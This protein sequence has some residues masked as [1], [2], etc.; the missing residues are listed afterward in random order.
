V[1]P[2]SIRL[3]SVKTFKPLGTLSYH[4]ESCTTLVFPHSIDNQI[5]PNV[6][7]MEPDQD[8]GD[9]RHEG[10]LRGVKRWLVSGGKDRRVALWELMDF[11]RKK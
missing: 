6:R 7:A 5:G 2:T 3:F 8:E 1:V 10:G 4:R 9:D 11:G